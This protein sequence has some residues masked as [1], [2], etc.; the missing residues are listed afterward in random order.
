MFPDRKSIFSQAVKAL[1]KETN[2]AFNVRNDLPTQ[3]K[4]EYTEE[5]FAKLL[6]SGSEGVS[7]NVNGSET[8]YPRIDTLIRLENTNQYSHLLSTRLFKLA[9]IESQHQP[10]HKIIAEFIAAHYL[11]KKV[12]ARRNNISLH[13]CLSII[14]PNGVVRDELRG[15]LAWMAA[16]GDK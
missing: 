7:T 2:G 3:R 14:A 12:N 4:I 10:S 11:V 13:Q 1:A 8:L 6:L 9:D 5:I 15:L 16:L